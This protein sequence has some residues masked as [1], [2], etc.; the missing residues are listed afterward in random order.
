MP[1][2]FQIYGCNAV[3]T[4][5][6]IL[7]GDDHG[8]PLYDYPQQGIFELETGLQTASLSYEEATQRWALL[9]SSNA[10]SYIYSGDSL[11]QAV[12]L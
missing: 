3:S 8:W 2:T 4:D 6:F 7:N 10:V 12:P 1:K 11:P 5:N 9:S